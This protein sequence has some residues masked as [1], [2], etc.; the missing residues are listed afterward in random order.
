M[1]GK[2]YRG[3]KRWGEGERKFTGGEGYAIVLE[4][5]KECW[6]SREN[7]V[8]KRQMRKQ[9]KKGEEGILHHDTGTSISVPNAYSLPLSFSYLLTAYKK[10]DDYFYL[11]NDAMMMRSQ[12]V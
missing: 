6:E 10:C 8:Q 7:R 4:E 5:Y 9:K 11:Y 3:M 2:V 12:I 1:D